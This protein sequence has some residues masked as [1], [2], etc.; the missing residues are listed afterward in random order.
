MKITAATPGSERHRERVYR[1]IGSATTANVGAKNYAT[2]RTL[3][4]A[5]RHA[6]RD[7]PLHRRGRPVRRQ[8]RRTTPTRRRGGRSAARRA[9]PT[10]TSGASGSVDLNI[11]D[12]TDTSL[13][14]ADRRRAG[15]VY[16]YV[17]SAGTLDL[18]A[19][20]YADTSLWAQ[21]GG[22]P[23]TAYQFVGS[24]LAGGSTATSTRRTTPTRA[25]GHRSRDALGPA[26][27]DAT[28]DVERG[29][30]RQRRHL[31]RTSSSSPRRRRRT[32]AARQS[33]RRSSTTSSRPTSSRPRARARSRFSQRV[34]IA[35]IERRPRHRRRRGRASRDGRD[36]AGRRRLRDARF[37]TDSGKRIVVTGDNVEAQTGYADRR[38]RRQGLP[39]PRAEQAARPRRAGLLATRISG[40]RSAARPAGPTGTSAPTPTLDLGAP[41][42]HGH[43]PLDAARR[44]R[45]RRLPV[46]G[47]ERPTLDLTAPAH[48]YTD[49]GWW[50]PVLGDLAH[51]AGHQRLRVELDRR[52]AG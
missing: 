47:P 52:S 48:P 30:D 39:V 35:A 40:R 8:R 7:L 23:D 32:T 50:K 3:E 28:G 10:A 43:A 42:L 37:T 49:L 34:R 21:L 15:R 25:S 2:A 17:G 11:Q 6:R 27:V 16:R 12:Y 26:I 29:R 31:R 4:A 36:R 9:R 24:A 1:Y 20:N 14:D 5:R 22:T 13:L 45:G 19:Q 51:P 46:D 33:R 44:Q 41:G 38:H 18:N